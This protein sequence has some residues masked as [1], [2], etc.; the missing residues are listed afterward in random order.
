MTVTTRIG[1]IGLG[2]MGSTV[3][4]DLALSR[5]RQITCGADVD[6]VVRE[7]TAGAWSIDVFDDAEAVCTRSDVDVVYIA[8][9]TGQHLEHGLLAL[10]NGKHVMIEKP[11]AV[12]IAEAAQLIDAAAVADRALISVGTPSFSAPLRAMHDVS[13]HGQ[14]GQPVQ[15]TILQYSPWM[16]RPRLDAEFDASNGGGVCFRQAPHQVDMALYLIGC[17]PTAVRAT[18]GQVPAIRKGEGHYTAFLDFENDAV[19]TLTYNGYG[20]FDSAEMN[21]SIGVDGRRRQI[22]S[23]ARLRAAA[24]SLSKDSMRAG[25][26]SRIEIGD[27]DDERRYQPA[28]GWLMLSCEGGDITQTPTGIRVYTP[29]GC[30]EIDLPFDEDGA[31]GTALDEFERYRDGCSLPLHDG[32]WGLRL[33]EICHAIRRSSET[34]EPIALA[35]AHTNRVHMNGPR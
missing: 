5:R 4:R 10:A 3:L 1:I 13:S 19:A 7:R 30:R 29:T 31:I 6:P 27:V 32:H 22:G 35:R 26:A 8:S 21:H 24:T 25:A 23:G 28:V 18:V 9:P 16:V 20:Y 15:L 33:V 34:A 2:L 17:E 14:L 11:L 12:T